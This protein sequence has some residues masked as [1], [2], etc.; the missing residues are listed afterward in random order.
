MN[1]ITEQFEA[2]QEDLDRNS[3]NELG[4][5][6]SK[7]KLFPNSLSSNPNWFEENESNLTNDPSKG[8]FSIP[9]INREEVM[10]EASV[11]MLC[12]IVISLI[13]LFEWCRIY[14]EI[15]IYKI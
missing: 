5:S 11:G 9:E 10:K 6:D 8:I 1:N 2:T 14:S 4:S 13:Y 7:K 12:N 15:L 3:Q